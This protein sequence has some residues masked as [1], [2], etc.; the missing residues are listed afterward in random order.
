MW[1]EKDAD[2]VQYSGY[3]RRGSVA[4]AGGDI[5]Q[6]AMDLKFNVE[7]PAH[8]FRLTP[9]P[10]VSYY[11]IYEIHI[12][13]VGTKNGWKVFRRYNDCY[14]FHRKLPGSI[15][16]HAKFP[17]KKFFG[18]M[19]A[20]F[21]EQRKKDLEKYLK[22]IL[23]I[24]NI[25][26]KHSEID[27]FFEIRPHLVSFRPEANEI[28]GNLVPVP[29]SIHAVNRNH[30]NEDV[31]MQSL[32]DERPFQSTV[33]IE[34]TKEAVLE[35]VHLTTNSTIV[36]PDTDTGPAL[37]APSKA[38]ILADTPP[39]S[40][41]PRRGTLICSGNISPSFAAPEY[42][43]L[44]TGTARGSHNVA[45]TVGGA[46]LLAGPRGMNTTLQP[47]VVS[48]Q[49]K[50]VLNAP[51]QIETIPQLPQEHTPTQLP[52][53]YHTPTSEQ[54][55]TPTNDIPLPMDS[56]PLDRA[57]P[58]EP[59][60]MDSN[61]HV[62]HMETRSSGSP[63]E[64]AGSSVADRLAA[65][66][67]LKQFLRATL[68]AQG[69]TAAGQ[70]GRG[71]STNKPEQMARPV[72]TL[73]QS[74]LP[75][76]N[77][78]SDTQGLSE[79]TLLSI[80]D[81]ISQLPL[82]KASS[83]HLTGI[84][85][86]QAS[87]IPL[88]PDFSV[89]HLPNMGPNAAPSLEKKPLKSALKAVPIYTSGPRGSAESALSSSEESTSHMIVNRRTNKIIHHSDKH[90]EEESD[91]DDTGSDNDSMQEN[92]ARGNELA[93]QLMDNMLDAIRAS[94]EDESSSSGSD[95]NNDGEDDDDDE[96]KDNEPKYGVG[97][98]DF[99]FDH[100]ELDWRVKQALTTRKVQFPDVIDLWDAVREG[101]VDEVDSYLK[102]RPHSIDTVNALGFTPLILAALLGHN[103]LLVFLV[104]KGANV[105]A[106]NFEACGS[107]HY[108]VIDDNVMMAT[109]L[110]EHEADITQKDFSG[111]TPIDMTENNVLLD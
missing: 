74:A 65:T 71:S 33:V 32:R 36:D 15:T 14:K 25:V 35:D 24:P 41:E 54:F 11:T 50:Q 30:S 88:G 13:I 12:L 47:P 56:S 83:N 96:F 17:G 81:Y 90:D 106:T 18:N 49:K 108:A 9:G 20:V 2:T 51:I 98:V 101:N 27:A 40:P 67:L 22:A 111:K 64:S 55:H 7:I 79:A 91:D 86:P 72:H 109:Y 6:L 94:S 53:E 110:I 70:T 60:S 42:T 77:A 43:P 61:R 10:F 102:A 75:T 78:I 95:L 84:S 39:F 107:L 19:D 87:P 46:S 85:P 38:P 31:N 57:Y 8:D 23:A 48:L 26:S 66:S 16:R 80:R 82:V 44:A 62:L 37:W 29:S 93:T 100:K 68:P 4:S 28:D 21:I 97:M 52:Q 89:D 99:T 76:D 92:E 58:S 69:H 45:V 59:I 103:D 34:S 5:H 3:G 105:N 63:T 73:Q 104:E 1:S